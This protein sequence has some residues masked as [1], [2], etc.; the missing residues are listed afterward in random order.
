MEEATIQQETPSTWDA[1]ADGLAL[2][3]YEE[4]TPPP[5]S[6]SPEAEK[7]S[8]PL[9]PD[10]VTVDADGELSF[11]DE[12]FA[13]MGET[14]EA[15]TPPAQEEQPKLYTA[16]ELKSTP[17]E[18][19][20]LSRLKGDVI[21]YARI[22]QEQLQQRNI[23]HAAQNTPLPEHLRAEPKPYTP[24]E[25]SEAGLKLAC[26]KLGLEEVDDFDSYESEHQAA[27]QMALQELSQ[28]RNAE[29]MSYRVGVATWPEL[30]QFNAELARQPDYREF[31]EWYVREL[32]K[33]GV[34]P[35]Q[36]NAGLADYALRNG[37]D[38]RIIA[39]KVAGW[40]QQF[41]R[42]RGNTGRQSAPKVV[43]KARRVMPP[44]PLEGTRGSGNEGERRVN[45]GRLGEMTGE[46]QAN[47]LMRLG[48]V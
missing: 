7:P 26:E 31:N 14:P 8:E 41:Q 34:T 17:F 36:M 40:Y 39:Q 29:I 13:G 21:E 33:Q 48:I 44:A 5:P 4:P 2:S 25:L 19:W 35:E 16:D 15:P 22:V 12:F 6:E 27:Y 1:T 11:G 47:E 45:I 9:K 46:E 23:Q 3:G 42:E 32:S 37:N 43:A 28:R 10:G 18:R 30:Q 38:Y 20:D 24:K